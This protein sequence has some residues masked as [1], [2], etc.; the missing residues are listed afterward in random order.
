MD[1]LDKLAFAHLR[2]PN[3]HLDPSI[4]VSAF[5]TINLAHIKLDAWEQNSKLRPKA[6][7]HK[8]PTKGAGQPAARRQLWEAFMEAGF[9]SE[10]EFGIS[11]P[12]IQFY[13]NLTY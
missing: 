4:Y 12:S 6:S 10:F 2:E 8:G 13:M 1:T 7:L 11:L 9:R 5:T 3:R